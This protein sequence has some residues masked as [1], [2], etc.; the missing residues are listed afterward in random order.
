[1]ISVRG[2]TIWS[3]LGSGAAA[4][5][6]WLTLLILARMGNIEEAGRFSLALSIVSPIFIFFSFSL[7]S[8]FASSLN[9]QIAE[10]VAARAL[11]LLLSAASLT[12]IALLPG[13]PVKWITY[14]YIYKFIEFSADLFYCIPYRGGSS[15]GI[16]RS[17]LLRNVIYSLVFISGILLGGSIDSSM[18]GALFL[19]AAYFIYSD[20]KLIPDFHR[21]SWLSR[22]ISFQ[23]LALA[24]LALPLTVASFLA[25]LNIGIPRYFVEYYYGTS[26]QALFSGVLNLILLAQLPVV[27][28]ANVLRPHIFL[29]IAKNENR[30]R[31]NFL[32]SAGFISCLIASLL[33]LVAAILFGS[34]VLTMIYGKGFSGGSVFFVMGAISAFFFLPGTFMLSVASS[35]GHYIRSLVAA[36]L[37]VLAALLTNLVIFSLLK[38]S[39]EF[40]FFSL[41]IGGLVFIVYGVVDLKNGGL[42][43][44]SFRSTDAK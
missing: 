40:G 31:V 39:P 32:V 17:V 12:A 38:L 18:I 42:L 27:S 25:A 33:F 19:S 22:L 29:A 37:A 21:L 9:I 44:P 24:K 36:L 3:I 8:V 23:T 30:R 13:T 28:F 1:M 16:G 15:A 10:L 26:D 34:E 43:S 5:S 20:T 11:G 7:R 4:G 2:D 35:S 41:S 6:S 14:L